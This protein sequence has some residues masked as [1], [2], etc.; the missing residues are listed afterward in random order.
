MAKR[1]RGNNDVE[2]EE[3]KSGGGGGGAVASSAARLTPR[4]LLPTDRTLSWVFT[5]DPEPLKT[6]MHFMTNL[7]RESTLYVSD[8]RRA[9]HD[10]TIVGNRCV[11]VES[12]AEDRSSY[13]TVAQL[14]TTTAVEYRADRELDAL[15]STSAKRTH[16][17]SVLTA[18]FSKLMK[19]VTASDVLVV[20]MD[21]AKD[22]EMCIA[23]CDADG[24]SRE[25]SLYLRDLP[26]QRLEV[27]CLDYVYEISFPLKDLKEPV[28]QAAVQDAETITLSLRQDPK[29]MHSM[30]VTEAEGLFGRVFMAYA[31]GHVGVLRKKNDA[32]GAGAAPPSSSASSTLD[33][34]MANLALDREKVAPVT[35]DPFPVRKKDILALPALYTA[36][37]STDMLSKML[38]ALSGTSQ[39]TMFMYER[40]HGNESPLVMQFDLGTPNSFISF[41]M[42]PKI[43]TDA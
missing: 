36:T 16:G 6:L 42:A 43:E 22:D 17:A 26:D 3:E 27:P 39:L 4:A 14:T 34:N 35:A 28:G 20:Y 21:A 11:I 15:P 24:K 33:E 1:A 13:L 18:Q 23:T 10:G 2:D 31:L 38:N 12:M 9:R 40:T 7:H 37:F 8:K 25:Q 32:G 19:I 41:I 29:T 5:V 30:L